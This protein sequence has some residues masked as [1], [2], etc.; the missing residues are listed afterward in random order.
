M[1]L[2]PSLGNECVLLVYTVLHVTEDEEGGPFA[3]PGDEGLMAELP[4]QPL[5]GLHV[6]LAAVD[7][8]GH[9]LGRDG[10]RMEG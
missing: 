10:T 4:H 5:D 2:L 6:G 7:T 3:L 1:Y 8:G 9:T